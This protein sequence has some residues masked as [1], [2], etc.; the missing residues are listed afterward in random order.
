MSFKKLRQF[1]QH[2]TFGKYHHMQ[3]CDDNYEY[4]K[5]IIVRA[6]VS[7]QEEK[8]PICIFMMMFEHDL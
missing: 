4:I 8:N 1:L 3:I 6:F 7:F 5:S 2:L